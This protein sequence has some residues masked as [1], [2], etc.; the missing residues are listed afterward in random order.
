MK[1]HN[2][3]LA[4]GTIFK[5]LRPNLSLRAETKLKRGNLSIWSLVI[6]QWSLVI[7]QC[8]HCE[9][10]ASPP[11]GQEQAGWSEAE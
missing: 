9:G 3:G 10:P 4:Q 1:I 6:S 2:A 7:Y 11:V 8:C 5:T